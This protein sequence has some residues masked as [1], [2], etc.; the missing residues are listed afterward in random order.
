MMVAQHWLAILLV[1]GFVTNVVNTFNLNTSSCRRHKRRRREDQWTLSLDVSCT[2]I[3]DPTVDVDDITPDGSNARRNIAALVSDD[4]SDEEAANHLQRVAEE[5]DLHIV[6]RPGGGDEAS[7][8]HYLTTTPIH[9]NSYAIAIRSAQ[10]S[11]RKRRVTKL[12]TPVFIDILPPPGSKLGYRLRNDAVGGMEMLVKALGIKRIIPEKLAS[13]EKLVVFDLTAGL[14]RDSIVII[15]SVLST[16]STKNSMASFRLLMVERD[17]IVAVLLKDAL[18]RVGEMDD[19]YSRQVKSCVAIQEGDSVDV[20]RMLREESSDRRRVAYPPDIIYLD[21][22][23]PPRKKRASAVKKDLAMLHALLGTAKATGN[24]SSSRIKEERAL[25][26]SAY[27]A[28]TKRVV[29]K[30]PVAAPP[31][32]IDDDANKDSEIPRPSF[33]VKGSTNRFDVYVIS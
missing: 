29:I 28:A 9:T 16:M 7:Y 32:G 4:P 24:N 10:A 13:G 30:R 18:R 2:S 8:T 26:L 19:E 14:A 3:P 33:E 25:L 11:K 12:E 21:P 20:L 6:R 23:F 1:G 31:L 27:E 15:S 17:P 5:L 22:M